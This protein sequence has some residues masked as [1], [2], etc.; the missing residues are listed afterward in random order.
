[1]EFE[2]KIKIRPQNDILCGLCQFL[3]D[4]DELTAYCTLYCTSIRRNPKY[5]LLRCGACKIAEEMYKRE[6]E[7]EIQT[8]D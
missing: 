5:R 7:N 1:M 3:I 2:V 4:T 8:L 6:Q